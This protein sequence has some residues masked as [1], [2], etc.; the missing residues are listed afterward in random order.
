M[1]SYHSR[2]MQMAGMND[3]VPDSFIAAEVLPGEC[4]SDLS[5]AHI[6]QEAV[7]KVSHAARKNNC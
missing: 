2:L 7:P 3:T 5:S 6:A 1:S 4:C